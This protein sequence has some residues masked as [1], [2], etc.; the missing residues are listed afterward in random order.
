[1]D[2]RPIIQAHML[3]AQRAQRVA[4]NRVRTLEWELEQVR[5][6][7]DTW[8][9]EYDKMTRIAMAHRLRASALWELCCKIMRKFIMSRQLNREIGSALVRSNG[10]RLELQGV[11]NTMIP[12]T[13]A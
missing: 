11:V 12:D 7:R 8:R 2:R 5:R 9:R 3:E 4:E 13:P 1:M 6:D 10:E